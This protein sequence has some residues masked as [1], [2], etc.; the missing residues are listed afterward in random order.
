MRYIKKQEEIDAY[1]FDGTLE[2][3]KSIQ[4]VFSKIRIQ[5]QISGDFYSLYVPTSEGIYAAVKGNWIANGV[6][7]L[8]IYTDALFHKKFEEVK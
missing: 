4:R 6:N 5:Q 3:A 2:C 7:G 1:Q 8:D